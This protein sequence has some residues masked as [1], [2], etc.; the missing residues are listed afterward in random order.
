MAL[1]ELD[2]FK[3]ITRIFCPLQLAVVDD[4]EER[5][6]VDVLAIGAVGAVASQ[7]SDDFVHLFVVEE[8]IRTVLRVAIVAQFAVFADAD[9]RDA[10]AELPDLHDAR[11]G[12]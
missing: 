7:S 12:L 4:L 6:L 9:V 8:E 2:D 5:V 1:L 10:R 3:G 11:E